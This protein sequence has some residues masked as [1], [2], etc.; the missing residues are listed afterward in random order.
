MI[1]RFF[2]G[3]GFSLSSAAQGAMSDL[4]GLDGRKVVSCR[5]PSAVWRWGFVHDL[6]RADTLN[7]DRY[8]SYA[9]GVHE[10]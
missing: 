10:Q 5:S 3:R 8:L 4:D 6:R 1:R 2:A 7:P 9:G